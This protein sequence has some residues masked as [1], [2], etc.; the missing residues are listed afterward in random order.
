M[1]AANSAQFTIVF[2]ALDKATVTMRNINKS[3]GGLSAPF[4][5]IGRRLT[6]LAEETGLTT[7][8]DR[9]V[10]VGEKFGALGHQI[11]GLLGPLAALGA[12]GTA[13]GL[14]EMAKG[15]A[16]FGKQLYV[17]QQ[18]TGVS[19]DALAKLHFAGSTV[20]LEADQMDLSI[21]R[22]NRTIAQTASGR[23][24]QAAQL[25]REMHISLFNTNGK[26]KD[27][28]TLLPELSKHFAANA[29][30]AQKTNAAMM[31]MGRSGAQMLPLFEM[32]GDEMNKLF[33][34][35]EQMYGKITPEVLKSAR[36][37]SESFEVLKLAVHGLS[38][39]IGSALFPVLKDIITP[40]TGWIAAHRQLVAI[41][42]REWVTG[43]ATALKNIDWKAVGSA[44]MGFAHALEFVGKTLGPFWSTMLVAGA[45][46]SPFITGAFGAVVALGRL[47]LALGGV[48]TRIVAFTIA[49][50]LP[51]LMVDLAAL[52]ET[53][54]PALSAA[55]LSL[56]VA[57]E[58]T[59]IG[60]II[61]GI[62]A[63]AAGA[64]L[65]YEYWT[66]IKNFF[67]SLWD[68]VT[69]IFSGAATA[70]LSVIPGGTLVQSLFTNWRAI[71]EFFVNLWDDVKGIFSDA[72]MAILSVIPGGTL[73]QNIVMNWRAIPEF[74]VGLWN[75]VKPAFTWLKFF[76]IGVSDIA[77]QGIKALWQPVSAFFSSLWAD[78]V[79]VTQ[80]AWQG[81]GAFFSGVWDGIK[82]VFVWGW[83]NVVPWIPGLNLVK[84]VI[85][86][87]KPIK[88][89]F[90][91]L[92]ADVISIF[93]K[94]WQKLKPIIETVVGGAKWLAEHTG[95]LDA[96]NVASKV[97]HVVVHEV[98][99]KAAQIGRGFEKIEER[100]E[101]LTRL[102]NV[103]RLS[104]LIARGEGT[105]NS[106]N[107]GQRGGYRADTVP[108]GN[109]TLAQVMAAQAK[110]QFN[111][112]GRYQIITA[113]LRDAVSRLHLNTGA[114][115]DAGMQDRIFKQYL[116]GM[117]HPEIANYLSRRNNDVMSAARAAS[118]EWASIADPRTGK[119]H[120]AGVG[121]NKA[122]ISV[123]EIVAALQTARVPSD[124]SRIPAISRPVVDPR[125]V[126]LSKPIIS[127]RPAS[128]GQQPAQ[129]SQTDVNIHVKGETTKVTS[130][131]TGGNPA[132][133]TVDRGK[134]W[135]S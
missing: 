26:L 76:A 131:S 40:I 101:A 25:F 22:L 108:L 87:W 4:T 75:K 60:W 53:A 67:A 29:S 7:L 20:G 86:N 78:V 94:M 43:I 37:G 47:G 42:V 56:G 135:A 73:V 5:D 82:T 103:A 92:W 119:S 52:T 15:A 35:F 126:A 59:P 12:A 19:A 123:A 105:Y 121:N 28:I 122:S 130:R 2:T 80:A 111:A 46:F 104:N 95:L 50:G 36:E 115:F 6:A 72:G 44:V 17:A 62:A 93:D 57:I 125:A 65:L 63:V 30:I 39:T 91:S 90:K 98:V 34:T 106:V 96:Y 116:L 113:T 120:Y 77:V 13:A 110:H 89:F 32:G 97:T 54:L 134:S 99:H 128:G 70:I 71:P 3:I 14:F 68:G 9:A 100:R 132:N 61:T 69:S 124:A 18:R 133:V 49:G 127:A 48:L 11:G 109:M 27:A 23:N 66:P 118:A 10:V 84:M 41:R 55:F 114:K 79:S 74:F 51:T 85:D 112:A 21:E 81:I 88:Q 38:F 107:L 129:K 102:G 1:A 58:A 31:L 24:K 45:V 64:Y 8:G 16:E 83:N 117:K 33:G